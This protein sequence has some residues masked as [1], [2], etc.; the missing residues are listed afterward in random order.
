MIKICLHTSF[1]PITLLA[2]LLLACGDDPVHLAREF[3]P[4]RAPEMLELSSDYPAGVTPEPGMAVTVTCAFRDP[5]GDRVTVNFTSDDG[6]FANLVTEGNEAAATF[7]VRG[8]TGGEN[9]TV[10]AKLGDPG[11]KSVTRSLDLGRSALGPVLTLVGP[12][13]DT[14]GADGFGS[15]I[16]RSNCDG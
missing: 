4:N 13:N 7:I 1:I 9:V 16:F 6:S 10:T 14:I 5:D 3:I 15:V 12:I 11:G 8:I 2:T